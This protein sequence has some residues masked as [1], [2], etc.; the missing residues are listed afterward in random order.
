MM[1]A[2][3]IGGCRETNTGRIHE[4]HREGKTHYVMN[5]D[6]DKRSYKVIYNACFD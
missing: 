4:T 6:A 1:R 3:L 5:K 2:N